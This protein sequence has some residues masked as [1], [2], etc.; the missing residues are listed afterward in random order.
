MTSTGVEDG[1]VRVRD[2][3]VD[4]IVSFVVSMESSMSSSSLL[5]SSGLLACAFFTLLIPLTTIVITMWMGW[6]GLG[7]V[8][9]GWVGM[10]C[11]V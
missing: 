9:L 5:S 11:E 10:G 2:F 1:L 7:W 8:G 4:S 3:E 6:D